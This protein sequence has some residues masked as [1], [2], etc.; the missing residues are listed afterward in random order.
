MA[1][2]GIKTLLGIKPPPTIWRIPLF[3]FKEKE[4]DCKSPLYSQTLER[5]RH[6]QFTFYS[7]YNST[8]PEDWSFCFQVVSLWKRL[9]SV[10]EFSWNV[11][12][13]SVRT[14]ALYP[15]PE[16]LPLLEPLIYFS[17]AL[18]IPLPGLFQSPTH[19][20]WNRALTYYCRFLRR[21][22][23]KGD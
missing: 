2:I 12:C 20:D 5:P 4:K 13:S 10:S 23:Q 22:W 3:M 14:V 6:F 17:L 8:F 19:T 15:S 18:W 11:Q 7:L 1:T 16:N 21:T 9:P